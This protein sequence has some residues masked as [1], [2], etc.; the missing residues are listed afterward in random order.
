MTV[1]QSTAQDVEALRRR[2]VDEHERGLRAVAEGDEVLAVFD[3]L[4]RAR[5]EADHLR[6]ALAAL[7]DALDISI[8]GELAPDAPPQERELAPAAL[9]D[10]LRRAAGMVEK[11][12]VYE[13]GLLSAV[14]AAAIDAARPTADDQELA[15]VLASM[16]TVA[17]EAVAAVCH[18]LGLPGRDSVALGRHYMT[19][20]PAQMAED[21]RAAALLHETRRGGEPR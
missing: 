7:L 18:F 16:H 6:Q 9:A 20:T 15:E 10:V 12:V 1:K 5:A 17:A 11:G 4:D 2:I 8:T 19:R 3:E 13:A 21:L 14:G